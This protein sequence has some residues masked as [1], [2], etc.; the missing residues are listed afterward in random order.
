MKSTQICAVVPGSW[1]NRKCFNPVYPM[2]NISV[3]FSL[4]EYGPEDLTLTPQKD[5]PCVLLANPS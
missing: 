4:R 2:A 3:H 1:E 5:L